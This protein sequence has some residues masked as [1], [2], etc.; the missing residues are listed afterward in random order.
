MIILH[1]HHSKE[2]RDFVDAHAKPS[3]TIISWYEGGREEW[4]DSGGTDKV[5]AF[6]SVVADIPE[7]DDPEWTDPDTNVDYPQSTIP[8]VQVAVTVLGGPSDIDVFLDETNVGLARSAQAGR[9]VNPMTMD[10]L[11]AVRKPPGRP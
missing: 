1:N 11:H 8:A 5:S 2:S 9:P 3:D 4:V 6:P 10:S 7:Y